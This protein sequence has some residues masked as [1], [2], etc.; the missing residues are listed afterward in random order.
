MEVE[1]GALVKRVVQA[2]NLALV[3]IRKDV[4]DS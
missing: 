3:E 4:K 2:L 1:E